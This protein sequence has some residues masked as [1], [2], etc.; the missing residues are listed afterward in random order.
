V[1]WAVLDAVAP[2]AASPLYFPDAGAPHQPRTLLL[3]GTFQSDVWV[4]VTAVVERKVAAV[5]CH[6][7]RVGGE[8]DLVAS[9]SGRARP[10]PASLSASATPRR[11][12]G[13]G[14]V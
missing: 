3:S 8:P 11:S 4:D 7:S 6:E 5:Q 13:S 10:R 9:S 14:S 2:A 12:A 1:G